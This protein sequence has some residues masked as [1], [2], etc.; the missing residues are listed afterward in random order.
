MTDSRKSFRRRAI[1]R[2]EASLPCRTR[3]RE[4][5][6]AQPRQGRTKILGLCNFH[7]IK[8]CL[9]SR[10]CVDTILKKRLTHSLYF[11]FSRMYQHFF[12]YF[13]YPSFFN[14]FYFLLP[15]RSIRIFIY[16]SH[17]WFYDDKLFD[18]SG[19]NFFKINFK[20]PVL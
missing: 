3:M 8:M 7:D 13:L 5:G 16:L 20:G 11:E 14:I 19:I 18:K 15:S 2:D 1:F 4:L 12:L 6:A 10:N 17:A 9:F